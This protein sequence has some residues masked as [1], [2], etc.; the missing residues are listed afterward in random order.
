MMKFLTLTLLSALEL[1]SAAETHMTASHIKNMN[2]DKVIASGGRCHTKD[3]TEAEMEASNVFVEDKYA[4]LLA[5]TM[6]DKDGALSIED[7]EAKLF[8]GRA[9]VDVYYHVLSKTD[10]TGETS[11]EDIKLQHNVLRKAFRRMGFIFR[12]KGITRT[13]NDAWHNMA[14]DA[15]EMAAKT[16]LHVGD[17]STLNVYL[18]SA[19]GYLG[20]AYFPGTSIPRDGVV[21]HYQSIPNGGFAPYDLGDTLVHEVGH[22]LGL[23][24]T[25]EGG[26]S[27]K[28]KG[29]DEVKDTP[30]VKE[31]NFG[32]PANTDSCPGTVR[33][34]KGNDLIENFMDYTDDSC[35]DS[36]TKQQKKRMQKQWLAYRATTAT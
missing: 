25:F 7:A 23:H 29:G 19:A 31:A 34:Q 21:L 4:K 6:S 18:N 2:R 22:W 35:M 30:A 17:S 33:A 26:C 3:Q 12:K 11:D 9:N 15:A 10:G 24:H 5:D 14:N 1:T 13:T 28:W 32:C 20:Y 16:A 8:N 36:F 27:K